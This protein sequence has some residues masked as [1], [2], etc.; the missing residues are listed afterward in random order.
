MLRKQPVAVKWA[1]ASIT[2]EIES[3][4]YRVVAA[5]GKYLH[6]ETASGVVFADVLRNLGLFLDV[7]G[8]GRDVRL[9]SSTIIKFKKSSNQIT[10]SLLEVTALYG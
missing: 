4:K 1:T 6:L 7:E 9:S 5:R 2:H 3:R 8:V 10:K